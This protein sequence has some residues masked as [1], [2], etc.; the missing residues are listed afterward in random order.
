MCL[1]MECDMSDWNHE[2]IPGH[3]PNGWQWLVKKTLNMIK[4]LQGSA[5]SFQSNNR[6]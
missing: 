4:I 3:W 2:P 5:L 6:Y 1:I